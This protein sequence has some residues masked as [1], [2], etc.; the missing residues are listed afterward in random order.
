MNIEEDIEDIETIFNINSLLMTLYY[1]IQNLSEEKRIEL[2]FD[3]N[4]KLPRNLRGD[5]ETLLHILTE[6]LTFIFHNSNKKEIVLSLIS[7]EDFLYE[8][9]ISFKISPTSINKEKIMSLLETEL[10]EDIESLEGKIIYDQDNNSDI[11]LSIPF[12]IMELGFR[13]HYRLPDKEMVGK[14]V[15]LICAKD[16]TAQSIKKMFEYF[17]YDVHTGFEEFEQYG[18]DLSAYD[19]L[20]ISEKI[21]TE[22]FK[23]I[24]AE[25]QENKALKYVLL[26]EPR[27]LNEDEAESETKYFIKPITQEKVFDLIISICD[28]KHR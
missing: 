7:P 11:H 27:T 10:A 26:E 16:K 8:E 23:K 5:P 3:M 14:K 19:L 25:A 13:R 15:L 6:I 21:I 18:N 24:I 28:P 2:I 12:K 22:E 1:H 9:Y 17:L 4:S 20:I